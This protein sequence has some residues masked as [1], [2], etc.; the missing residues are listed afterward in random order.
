[1]SVVRHAGIIAAMNDDAISALLAAADSKR[2]QLGLEA[3]NEAERAISLIAL[4]RQEIGRG[5]LAQFYM[6]ESGSWAALIVEALVQVGAASLAEIVRRAN[7][8]FP[9]GAPPADPG[10]RASML[11]EELAL[12]AMDVLPD[13]DDAFAEEAPNLDGLLARYAAQHRG[14]LSDVRPAES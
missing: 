14:S 3:L 7:S 11:Q 5:G 2:R 13:L 9:G 10:E 8:V 4:A 12:I 1:M 6:H